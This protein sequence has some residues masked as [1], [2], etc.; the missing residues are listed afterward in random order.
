MEAAKDFAGFTMREADVLRKG[1]DKKNPAFIA[2]QQRMF[3]EGDQAAPRQGEYVEEAR[4]L[5]L[6]VLPPCVRSSGAMCRVARDEHGNLNTIRFGLTLIK[7]ASGGAVDWIIRSGAN[8]ATSLKEFILACYETRISEQVNVTR[9]HD[10]NIQVVEKKPEWK[11]YTMVGKTDQEALTLA[12]AFHIFDKDR[13][14]ILQ[15]LPALQKLCHKWHEQNAKLKNGKSVRDKPDDVWKAIQSYRIGDDE[16]ANPMTLEQRIEREREVT[17]CFLSIS[18]FEPYT[19]VINQWMTTSPDSIKNG[20]A[21]GKLIFPAILTRYKEVVCKNGR[22]RGR[23]MSRRPSSCASSSARRTA[24]RP[25]NRGV[26]P[27][28]TIHS[29]RVQGRRTLTLPRPQEPPLSD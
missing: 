10:A 2:K 17:G 24:R 11:V 27:F 28:R 29:A 7:K 20:E 6:K 26:P 12:G 5:G 14:R 9:N 16:V 13:A 22:S 25:L 4:G 15:M 8:K 3:Y 21:Y 18:P 19:T 23:S 1:V